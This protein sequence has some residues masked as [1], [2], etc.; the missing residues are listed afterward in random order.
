MPQTDAEWETEMRGFIENYEFPTVG[1]W[2]G[3]HVYISTKLKSYF[4]FK[5]RYSMSNLALVG[6]NKRILS[7][8]VGAPG[9]THDARLLRNTKIYR[10]IL[11]GRVLPNKGVSLGESGKIPL[12]TIG[13]SAFP[14]HSWLLKGFNEATTD[15][16]HRLFNKKLCSARVVTENAFGMLKGR[17]RFLYRKTECRM[18]NLK[19]IILA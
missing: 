19:Y 14:K 7:C 6:Y 12:V 5:K 8:S 16:L 10:D 11:A 15:P 1:A 4:S 13:D 2:D 18:K 17:F 9:S 3:F